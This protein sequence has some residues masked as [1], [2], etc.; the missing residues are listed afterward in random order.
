MSVFK[1][2][3][4][5][6]RTGNARLAEKYT[7]EF[8]DHQGMTRRVTGTVGLDTSRG[9]ERRLKEIVGCKMAGLFPCSQLS[10]WLEKQDAETLVKLADWDIIEARQ[11]A[12]GRPLAGHLADFKDALE[13]RGR[14]PQHVAL[15]LQRVTDIADGCGFVFWADVRGAAVE[16]F[17]SKRRKE[18]LSVQS[19][20]HYLSNVK[21]FCNWMVQERR[22]SENPLAHLRPRTVRKHDREERR[23]LTVEE[24]RRLLTAAQGGK[25]WRGMAGP[26]RAMLYETAL[27]TGLRW[28]ELHALAVGDFDLESMDATVTLGGQ[29][30]KNHTEA[31]QPVPQRTAE[32]LREHFTMA[33]DDAPAFGMPRTKRGADMMRHDLEKARRLYLKEAGAD[34]EE[35][36]LRLKRMKVGFLVFD[37][38]LG[39]ADFHSLRHTF[40][41]GLALSGVDVKT[42]MDLARHSDPK[43]TLAR[44]SHTV[45]A[46]K[47]DAVAKLPDL[48]GPE[49]EALAAT[50]TEDAAGGQASGQELTGFDA[51][52]CNESRLRRPSKSKAR[53][54]G[55]GPQTQGKPNVSGPSS[56]GTPERIRTSGLRFRKPL[57]YPTELRGHGGEV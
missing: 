35:K 52:S 47:S 20:N 50:G 8:A 9:M 1:R 36:R 54:K 31:V 19:F 46:N 43:L 56:Y 11:R 24:Q 5:G 10:A 25:T 6:A 57:L 26:D 39:R 2:K 14:T 33:L 27:T 3:R 15:V 55:K 21:Q 37:A 7:I 28:S 13:A 34:R 22:A 17:L 51:I 45:L 42:A 23:A 30:T 12:A 32:R 16:G 38:G 44:Y 53:S 18:G 49:H 41:T 29:H 48:S 4:K 40:I